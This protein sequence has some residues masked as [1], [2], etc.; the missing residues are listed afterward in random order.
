MVDSSAQRKTLELGC[1]I[2]LSVHD[3]AKQRKL[4]LHKV[5]I[6]NRSSFVKVR[7]FRSTIFVK[8]FVAAEF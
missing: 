1:K 4:C 2:F 7:K 3:F 8:K 6:E 5:N